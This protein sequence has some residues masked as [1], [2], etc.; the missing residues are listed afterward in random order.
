[1]RNDKMKGECETKTVY[2]MVF[3]YCYALLLHTWA[4]GTWRSD[5]DTMH[6]VVAH[7]CQYTLQITVKGS[8]DFGLLFPLKYGIMGPFM[9]VPFM[10]CPGILGRRPGPHLNLILR[11]CVQ[12]F[13]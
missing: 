9:L 7:I 5:P 10:E 8:L 4:R 1:M 12:M 13:Q 6:E 3:R 11:N 2:H